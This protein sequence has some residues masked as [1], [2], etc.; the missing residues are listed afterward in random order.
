MFKLRNLIWRHGYF[1]MIVFKCWF[2]IKLI[3]FIMKLDIR[4]LSGLILSPPCRVSVVL[5]FLLLLNWH[6]LAQN[7]EICNIKIANKV[8]SVFK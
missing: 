5:V 7:F 3:I 6:V 8:K 1:Y 4:K 2:Y